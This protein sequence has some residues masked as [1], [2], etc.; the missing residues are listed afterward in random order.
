MG[1]RYLITVKCSECGFIEGEV[2]YAPTCG[3]TDWNCPKCN[4]KVDLENYTG[5][6]YKDASNKELIEKIVKAVGK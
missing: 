5:I 6:S 2:Y 1:D 3:F 4:H